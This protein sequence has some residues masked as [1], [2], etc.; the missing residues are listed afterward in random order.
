MADDVTITAGSG[1]PIATDDCTSAHVQV[2]K[3]AYG[4]DG[5]RTHVP[6]DADGLLVN[7]GANNDISGAVTA[8]AGTN[9][10][11]S[12]LS[13]EATQ[14][15][16]RTAVQLIDDSVATLGT[17][18]YTE[19]TTKG[20]IVGAVRRDADTTAANT[21]NEVAP[22]LVNAIGA[23]KVEI[24]DG[25][26]SHTIDGTVTANLAAGT[27][28][29]GDVDILSIAAGDNNIGNVDIVT[30][31]NVTLAAGTNTNEI[32]GDAAHDVTA[33]G[34]PVLNGAQMETPADS[35]PGTRAST[36]GDANTLATIDG[37]LFVIPGGPQQWKA[38]L[39]G[40]M[41]DTTVKAAPGAGLSL[42]VHT[43][44]YSI[45][46]ATASS[47]L[48][49][50]STTTA[51]FGPHYLEAI[52]GRGL[53]VN[54]NPPIKIAAN[55]LLSATSTGATTNTLDVYGFTAPG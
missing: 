19:T 3:L 28:N 32:V 38:R 52:S 12:A 5:N 41:S 45:G 49:E 30:M 35:A 16:V 8:N 50:E 39:T 51:V 17:T 26:D 23:L 25:G 31:P 4:A 33:A 9:L 29:I 7:L 21:D 47:I 24:F 13:L 42:Y 36:D 54:F 2:V 22:L 43:V 37:A 11:T 10:N 6:A 40:S 1:T 15:D 53:A 20:L 44:V 55:T 18:T 48:L 27:N 46:A 14:A 34:N